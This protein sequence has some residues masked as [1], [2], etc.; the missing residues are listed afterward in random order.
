MTHVSKGT[1]ERLPQNT[2]PLTSQIQVP[3]VKFAKI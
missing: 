1:I 2:D 3:K